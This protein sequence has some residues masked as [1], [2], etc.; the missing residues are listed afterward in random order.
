MKIGYARTSTKDQK[1]SIEDQLE[2]LNQYGCEKVFSE[3]LSSVDAN[4]AELNAAIDYMREGDALVVTK[5]DRLARTVGDASKIID[6]LKRKGC[7]LIIL[8]FHNNSSLDTRTAAEEL[9]FNI[10]VAFAQ[11]EREVMLER[12]R[13]GIIKAKADGKYKGRK[14]LADPKKI[15]IKQLIAQGVKKV[16][17]A[18][19]VG[20]GIA[21]VHRVAK[22][23]REL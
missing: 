17:I 3:Q 12:Q 20:V 10:F 6:V 1:Y 9:Q 15:Q 21:T 14:A 16:D 8:N 22:E 13:V 18:K 23:L 19:Q 4:R 7:G 11:F 5:L 2:Q